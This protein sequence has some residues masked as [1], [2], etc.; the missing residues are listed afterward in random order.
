MAHYVIGDVQGCYQGLVALCQVIDFDPQ[1]DTLYFAGDLV[2][3]GPASLEVLRFIKALPHKIVVLGNHDLHLLALRANVIDFQKSHTLDDVL[4]AHD[5]DELIEWLRRQPLLYV[6]QQQRF[7]LS[8]AGILPSWSVD[9]AI[10]LAHEVHQVLISDQWPKLM[11]IMYGNSPLQWS[12]DLEGNDRLRMI[13]NVFTRMRFLTKEGKLDFDFDGTP[14]QSPEHLRP[15]Y[16]MTH[17]HEDYRLYFGHWAALQAQVSNDHVQS[18]DAG[19]V[20]GGKLFCQRIDDGKCFEVK[21][22][23]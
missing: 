6:D 16:E 17:Q 8:H 10:Q 5:V 12:N 18:L 7:A 9:Q 3:R 14:Q 20:W 21:A 11:A 22:Y 23:Q 19:Y 1:R 15:W 2:N 13:I 4:A